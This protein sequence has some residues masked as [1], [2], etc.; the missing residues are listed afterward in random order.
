[1]P[2]TVAE[3]RTSEAV[4]FQIAQAY[5]HHKPLNT[6]EESCYMVQI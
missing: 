5:V 4:P 1:M 2:G 3:S 6:Q